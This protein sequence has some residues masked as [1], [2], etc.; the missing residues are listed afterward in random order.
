MKNKKIILFIPVLIILVGLVIFS[1]IKKDHSSQAAQA[2]AKLPVSFIENRGQIKGDYPFYA[3]GSGYRFLFSPQGITYAFAHDKTPIQLSFP[4]A[5]P[6][7]IIS[8]GQKLEGKI[9]YLRGKDQS[10]WKTNL[11]TY[12]EVTYK[13]LY[14]GIDYVVL[15]KKQGLELEFH[16]KPEANPNQIRMA[17]TE[18]VEQLEISQVGDLVIKTKGGDLIEKKPYVYQEIKGKRIEIASRYWTQG[19]EYGFY[20]GSYDPQYNIVIDPTLIYSTYLGGS[21]YE[22]D[23]SITVDGDGN[24]L[25]TGYTYSSDFPLLNAFQPSF[26]GEKDVF[27]TKIASDGT[28]VYSTYLGGSGSEYYS[29]I[30]VDGDGNAL[31]T[32]STSSSDFPL[33]NAFQPSFGGEKDVFVT[34]IA[35]DGTVVYSTYLGGSG[36]EYGSSITVDGDGNALVTGLTYS[37]DFPLLNAFQPSISG[38]EDVF[39]TKIASDGTV[40]YSTYLGGSGSEYGY[41]ITVDGDGNALV[42]GYTYSSDFPLLNAF[43]P[44][45][46]GEED[47]FVTK[48][49]SDGTVV[50]S[51]YLG[52]SGSEYGYSITVD[53]DGNALVTGPT[54]SSDF[55]LLNAFQPSISGEEDVFVTK[56][57]S[58]G[59]VV[60]STYLGG[61][62]YEYDSSITVDGDGNALVTG[63]T[64]S[65]DFP[66]LNA[67]QPSISG[68]KDVFVTKIASDGTVVYSTY[69]GGSG[70]EYDSSI[71]VDGDGNALV[72]GSTSSSDFPLLNAFQPSISGEEDVFVTKIASD[73][74]V[75]Y[76]T[77]LGGSGSEYDFSITV[78]GDGN[79]LVTGY[80]ESSDFPLLNA[81]QPSFGGEKDVFVT[82][83]ASD[84]TVVYSTYL[85]G[86]G[87]EYYSSITV[88]GDGNALVTGSTSSS[89]FPLLN[90]FQ[91]SFGGEK[92]VFVTKIASDGTVVYSTYLGGSGYEYG[93]SITVDGDGNALVTGLTYSSDFPLLNAFQPSIS[94]GGDIFV[95]KIASDGTVVYSTYLGGSGSEYGYSITVDGDGNALVTGYTYSSDFPLLNAFQP[96]ISG[97]EDV[98]VTKIASDG[99]VVYSTYLGGSGYEYDSSIT[100]DGDGNALVTGSTSSSDFPLLNAFQPSISGEEDVFVTKIASDG[101]VVYS[102]YLGGSGSE[103]DFSITVDGDGNAL[104]TGYTESSDFPLLNAFQP[105]FGS[106]KDFFVTKIASDGTVV[107]STYLGGSGSEYYS[108]ITVDG[109]GNALVTGPTSSSDFPLLNAFQPSISGEEDVFVTKIAS[110][111]TV[112]Y[113]TYLGGSSFEYGSSITVDGDGNALVTGY[114]YSSDFPLLNA[115]QPSISG[116]E[117]VFVTKIASDG[118][119]VYSTYL[120]GSGSEYGL[121]ITVD[122]DGNALVTGLTY[123]S[124]FPLLNAFQPSNSGGADIFVTKICFSSVCIPE[125]CNGIDDD[126]DGVI[127]EGFPDTDGDGIADCVEVETCDGLDN[128]GNGITDEADCFD[129]NFDLRTALLTEDDVLTLHYTIDNFSPIAQYTNII[130]LIWEFGQPTPVLH[131]VDVG[132]VGVPA[133]G[134]ISGLASLNLSGYVNPW[135]LN[136][137]VGVLYNNEDAITE[138]TWIDYYWQ[139]F[140][141]F[142]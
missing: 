90:A 51:T 13:D 112:V 117:D 37:S 19:K 28:V 100:V 124:D 104:V 87:S 94:G 92:D 14:P 45:I 85:G 4:G 106:E 8:G 119:V 126:G 1:F 93:Y 86:S 42:T 9:N 61:S 103:Y 83:I 108:S 27:V 15:G 55:P 53:G 109:D 140:F 136:L 101:T 84:G 115:F 70:Y 127:D 16:I 18:G 91:P 3:Q 99:T 80:T 6:Q 105:S 74:T 43:Q 88:D 17:Y 81:F 65:S 141:V 96:S 12:G 59:T 10:Q 29:S 31:V 33:L 102:T 133:A 23:S 121:S 46:S 38:E 142:P 72:T 78:D 79:A 63:S 73:G 107:Y 50:Y 98:F 76:S 35:S 26:G 49:A 114:T 39:V 48:I 62:G 135:T 110:D 25:V 113:S 2:L 66:L 41:S 52:G 54:S 7:P 68:E 120:G 32:G 118:T 111:G 97:E 129:L 67:F 134:G 34:K 30:T 131:P 21:Y 40:V 71:T 69:L 95:T 77:Y 123:S 20:L 60:Y 89:D 132:P 22:R 36:Y 57:A 138:T 116:E 75:V 122:G 64:S 137:V 128:N 125:V 56:I 139:P 44:S 58:D 130:F 24:A 82:K 47:V 11:S 5:N